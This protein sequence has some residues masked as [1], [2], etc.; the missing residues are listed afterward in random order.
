VKLL[1]KEFADPYDT[2][3]YSI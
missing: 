2:C 3:S 1:V